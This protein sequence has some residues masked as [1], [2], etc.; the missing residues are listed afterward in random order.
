M[1]FNIRAISLV[2]SIPAD[3][4]V[5]VDELIGQEIEFRTGIRYS[6]KLPKTSELFCRLVEPERTLTAL[7]GWARVYRSPGPD[8]E[9]IHVLASADNDDGEL[10][11]Y[12]LDFMQPP[13]PRN[14]PRPIV[15]IIGS[16]VLPPDECAAWLIEFAYDWLSRPEE[17]ERHFVISRPCPVRPRRMR[18]AWVGPA[19]LDGLSM[20]DRLAAIGSVLGVE[21]VRVSPSSYRHV[22]NRLAGSLPLDSIII[23]RG[24]APYINEGVVPSGVS[25]E[26]IHFCDSADRLEIEQ[27]VTTWIDLCDQQA[28]N[29][30]VERT[31]ET[32]GI[33]LAIMLRGMLSHS[34]IGQ[35]KHCQKETVLKGVRARHLNVAAAARILDARS[36]IYQDT[37]ESEAFFLWKDHNDGRRYFLNPR[38]IEDIKTF[39]RPPTT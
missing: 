7:G 2:E 15:Q 26:R 1:E 17:K 9:N 21:I 27:Q 33:L 5:G 28:Q 13:K 34:K 3:A 18:L 12:R 10:V 6:L 20:S 14:G 22:Q 38:R 35:F 8:G 19:D 30:Q 16:A 37:R 23:C 25:T 29:E 32:E 36:E 11:F 4:R 24:H 39:I 31:P